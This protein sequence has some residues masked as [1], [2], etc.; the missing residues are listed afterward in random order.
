MGHIAFG[1]FSLDL[2]SARLLRDGVE[3]DLRPQV[4]SALRTLIQNCGRHVDYDH[5]IQQA[6]Q[7]VV[8]IALPL[9]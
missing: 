1:P 5:M 2:E 3:L 9:P 8:A 4:F 7:G 6:W